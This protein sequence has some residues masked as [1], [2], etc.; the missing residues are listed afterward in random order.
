MLKL[1]KRNIMIL[2]I[3]LVFALSMSSFAAAQTWTAQKPSYDTYV[4]GVKIAGTE[5]M[6]ISGTT[7]IKP[8]ALEQFGVSKSWD[9]TQADFTIPV[10]NQGSNVSYSKLTKQVVRIVKNNVLIGNG[11]YMSNNTVLTT[12]PLFDQIL[13]GNVR[14]INSI[15]EEIQM[16]KTP[17]K[18]NSRQALLQT[19]GATT[20]SFATLSANS[21]KRGDEVALIS[22]VLGVPN[23]VNFSTVVDY[24]NF[25]WLLN[26]NDGLYMRTKNNQNQLS[27]GGGMFNNNGELVGMY[28][29]QGNNYAIA[30]TLDDIKTFLD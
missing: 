12:R 9:G 27:Q 22:S 30:I 19:S 24:S 26:E 3:L 1:K 14:I 23:M 11:V 13:Q 15:G 29:V 17:I 18:K 28:A 21:P 25:S 7:Y 6:N 8:G 5:I 2:S 20:S 4:N 10:P 16:K